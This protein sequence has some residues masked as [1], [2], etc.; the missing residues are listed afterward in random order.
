[1]QDACVPL[2]SA[3]EFILDRLTADE[4]RFLC[5]CILLPCAADSPN[6]ELDVMDDLLKKAVAAFPVALSIGKKIEDLVAADLYLI[7]DKFELAVGHRL[8]DSRLTTHYALIVACAIEHVVKIRHEEPKTIEYLLKSFIAVQPSIQEV[9]HVINPSIQFSPKGSKARI[10][11]MAVALKQ[12]IQLLD[13]NDIDH[14]DESTIRKELK[15][16][17]DV[18]TSGKQYFLKQGSKLSFISRHG[19]NASDVYCVSSISTK[20][21][22]SVQQEEVISASSLGGTQAEKV[23]EKSQLHNEDDDGTDSDGAGPHAT[24][25]CALQRSVEMS[26]STIV[27]EESQLHNDDDDD[28]SAGPQATSTCVLQQSMEITESTIVSDA[29]SCRPVC[30]NLCPDKAPNTV[31][32]P[33]SCIEQLKEQVRVSSSSRKRS[34]PD[35]AKLERQCRSASRRL[36]LTLNSEDFVNQ[37]VAEVKTEAWKWNMPMMI[38][39]GF[40]VTD[41]CAG[42]TESVFFLKNQQEGRSEANHLELNLINDTAQMVIE[43]VWM[44]RMMCVNPKIL[45]NAQ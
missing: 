6:V 22:G 32:S 40:S 15:A 1:M 21:A 10:R 17:K 27:S 9:L 39:G 3:N 44:A 13:R 35:A 5:R 33:S 34:L 18:I 4:P 8:D 43:F 14:P 30:D 20:E 31:L 26:E 12:F 28:D 29:I 11:G 7:R 24:S 42:C 2:I 25:T 19:N 16:R 41:A 45:L 37:F 36:H 23:S 38:D